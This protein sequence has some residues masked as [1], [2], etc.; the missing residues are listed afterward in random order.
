MIQ[1]KDFNI[2]ITTND[3]YSEVDEKKDFS[4]AR[5]EIKTIFYNYN[6]LPTIGDVILSDKDENWEIEKRLFAGHHIEL[7]IKPTEL[8]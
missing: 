2:E 8:F 7:I 3:L 5:K 6:T 4:N 1:E